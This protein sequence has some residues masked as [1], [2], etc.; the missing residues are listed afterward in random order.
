MIGM[1]IA[2][3]LCVATASLLVT[4]MAAS[5]ASTPR[6]VTTPGSGGLTICRDWLVYASC[7]TYHHV[8]LPRRIVVGDVIT[9]TFGSSDKEYDFHVVGIERHGRTCTI[10]SRHTGAHNSGEKIV[11]EG[12]APEKQPPTR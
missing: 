8:T 1:R 2:G 10:K 6:A 12:C 5:G 7:G 11:V 4:P 3:M 9:L